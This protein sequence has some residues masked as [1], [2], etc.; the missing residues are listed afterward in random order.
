MNAFRLLSQNKI[1]HNG[2]QG[3]YSMT[4][5]AR[6][7]ISMR[8]HSS[9]SRW[10]APA[11]RAIRRT[12]GVVRDLSTNMRGKSGWEAPPLRGAALRRGADVLSD[13]LPDIPMPT[14]PKRAVTPTSRP[15]PPPEEL[16]RLIPLDPQR[17]AVRPNPNYAAILAQSR[18]ASGRANRARQIAEALRKGRARG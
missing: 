1:R 18:D 10:A 4:P 6:A 14:L 3:E 12:R 13:P 17:Q 8:K 16:Y 9:A 7:C 15:S 2:A 11:M 5:L